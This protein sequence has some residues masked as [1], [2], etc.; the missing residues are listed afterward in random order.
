M[1]I[2]QQI[3][4][5][6]RPI[7]SKL[8]GFGFQNAKD[9]F[10]FEKSFMNEDF[11]LV[12]KVSKDGAASSKVIDNMNDEEYSQINAD[13][14]VGGYVGD[15]RLAYEKILQ[16]IADACFEDVLFSSDQANR[17]AA[18]IHDV[19]GVA[20]DFPWND[21]PYSAAGVFRHA[22]SRNWFGLIMRINR[23]KLIP[24]ADEHELV[25]VINL[26]RAGSLSE[27]YPTGVF[28]AYHMNHKLWIS[29]LLDDT[30]SDEVVM[31]LVSASFLA[32]N[33]K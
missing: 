11:V 22:D 24:S 8:I 32:T 16:D 21:D 23:A 30:V 4:A 29:V 17:I 3:F 9:G 27:P 6:K 10:V 19:Y 1:T 33:K 25:D 5:R 14:I 2:F 31:A 28:P 7:F 12:F 20:P 13:G 15:V 26:K 18:K